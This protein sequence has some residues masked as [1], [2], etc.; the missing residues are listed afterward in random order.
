MAVNRVAL[1]GDAAHPMRPY[2]A[3]G[4]AMA[5]EDAWTLGKVLQDIAAAQVPDWPALLSRWAAVRW[6]RNAWVQRRSQRNGTVFHAEGAL[7]LGRNLAMMTLGS[8]LLDLPRLYGGPPP[9]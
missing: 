2:L 8:R 9:P 6:K 4:A 3:Q 1:L 7:R 5:L